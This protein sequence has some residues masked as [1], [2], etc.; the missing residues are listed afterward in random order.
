MLERHTAHA[1][2]LWTALALAGLAASVALPLAVAS[3]AATAPAA[4]AGLAVMH[5]TIGA[6]VIPAMGRT[7]RPRRQHDQEASRLTLNARTTSR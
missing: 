6:A 3:T 4:V 1:R 7:S 5:L 2:T